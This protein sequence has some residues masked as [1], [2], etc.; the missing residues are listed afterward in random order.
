MS[1]LSTGADDGIRTR[2][3]ILT[4]DVRYL[5]RHISIFFPNKTNKMATW[6]GVEP[7][8]SSVTG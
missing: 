7:T 2:D 1:R 8:T 3:L 6:M 5:L 4:K